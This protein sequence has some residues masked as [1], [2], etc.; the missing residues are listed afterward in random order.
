MTECVY[1]SPLTSFSTQVAPEA[2]TIVPILSQGKA[3]LE[4]I[5]RT[6]GLGF[7]PWDI[8]FYTQ[9]VIFSSLIMDTVVLFFL[10]M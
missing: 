10:F 1:S 7:D 4:A 8:D 9:M 2:V 5:N 3:A 6:K